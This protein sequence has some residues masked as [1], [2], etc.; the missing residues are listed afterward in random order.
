MLAI[1]LGYINVFLTPYQTYTFEDNKTYVP[2]RFTQ[3]IQ[4][5]LEGADQYIGAGNMYNGGVENLNALH[6]YVMSQMEK[7]TTKAALNSSLKA[8][9]IQNSYKDMNNNEKL[10]DEE[11]DCSGLCD[12]ICTVLA[13]LGYT[14]PATL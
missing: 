9:L 6:L 14:Q 8:Y 12:S 10:I 2:K 1:I 4:V 13:N 7:P 11:F 5:L 3:Y